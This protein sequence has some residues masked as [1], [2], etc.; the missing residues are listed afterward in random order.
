MLYAFVFC[1]LL[2]LAQSRL[3]HPK[4]LES[5]EERG[6]KEQKRQLFCDAPISKEKV[7]FPEDLIGRVD[8]NFD[9]YSGYVNVTSE[10]WL[11]Y[12]YFSSADKNPNA[13]V[14]FWTNGGP[15]CSS[16]EGATTEN[17]P[18]VLFDIKES[19]SSEDCD[20]TEQLSLNPYAWNAHAH[21]VYVDQPRYVGNSFGSG[22]GVH[23]SVEAAQ[24]FVTFYRGF[25][26]LFP[27]LKGREM[28]IS[29]ESYGGH[30]IPAFASAILNFNNDQIDDSTK[31]NF[32]GAVIGNGCVNDTVQN[33]EQYIN[34]LHDTNLIPEDATPK[35][36]IQAELQMIKNIGYIPNYYD[37]RAQSI[38]CDACYGYNYTAWSYWF[39][40]L[41]VIEAL[42]ICGD[43]GVD[44]FAGNSGGCIPMGGFDADDNFDYS[45]ALAQTLEAGI[46]VT[47]YYGMT[48]TACNYVG[49]YEMARTISWSGREK[50]DSIELSPLEI[51]GVSVGKTK[52]YGGLTWIE[53]ESAG[54]MVPMDQPPASSTAI[55]TILSKYL[56]NH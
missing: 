23:S 17:G 9:M 14:V 50:F 27:E 54:H 49:G 32:V 37:Y 48:D 4:F 51:A 22:E 24:D 12:W 31:I 53:V 20:Y 6:L 16:M 18:L 19:C 29:G 30:Y 28:I 25:I 36:Y 2:G 5:V 41:D 42:H 8:V 7:S 38:S 39:L 45:G 3:L 15:G 55:M 1:S 35:S 40:R 13:P 10:D 56:N 26:D 11:F 47:F 44:A 33:T 34:F 21:V 46:P 43:A 52:S